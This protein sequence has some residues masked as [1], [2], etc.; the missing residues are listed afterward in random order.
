M[1]FLIGLLQ[2][3]AVK[4]QELALQGAAA[5]TGKELLRFAFLLTFKVRNAVRKRLFCREAFIAQRNH[6]Q[7]K[8]ACVMTQAP[9]D[10]FRM[11]DFRAYIEISVKL[12]RIPAVSC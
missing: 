9:F 2:I 4:H 3:H 12:H 7:R 5:C 1:L 11:L 10:M 6:V 8:A